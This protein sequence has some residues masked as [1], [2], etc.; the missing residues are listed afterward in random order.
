MRRVTDTPTHVAAPHWRARR[1][2]EAMISRGGSAVDAAIASAAVLCVVYPHMVSLGGD[3]WALISPT[4]N[5]VVA[6]NGTGRAAANAS[7]EELRAVHGDSLPTYGIDTVTVPGG[8]SAW[9]EM[10]QR[11]GVLPW[12]ELFDDALELAGHGVE[13]AS[14]LSREIAMHRDRLRADPGMSSVFFDRDGNPLA[15]GELLRQ[16]A[17]ARTL[18]SIA[19]QGAEEF[20][21]GQLAERFAAAL[22][23][24]G[25]RLTA[26][27][28]ASH[29]ADFVDPLR[30]T[31]GQFEVI[32]SP[33]NSQGFVLLQLLAA[34]EQLGLEGR[35]GVER[36]AEV[37]QL[38]SLSNRERERHLAD[39]AVE[40]VDLDRLLSKNH[41]AELVHAAGNAMPTTAPSTPRP[42]GDTVAVVAMDDEGRS[43]TLIQSIFYAF[44]AM[45][46]ERDT[47]IVLQN[48]G[49][50]LS[51]RP[52]HPARLAGRA[53]PPHTLMPVMLA[54]DS[55]VEYAVGTMGGQ[56]QAQIQSQL[57]HNLVMGDSPQEAVDR[58]RWAVGPYGDPGT[59]AVLVEAALPSDV[60]DLLSAAGLPTIH[61]AT[62]DDRAGH[63]QIVHRTTEGVIA[64]TDPR[65][66]AVEPS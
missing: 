2:G 23:Q 12:K 10:H 47:G 20:Y 52:D 62:R 15:E 6:L 60:R 21:R 57:L 32:T 54:R 59:D 4:P 8:V 37:A 5:E 56:A 51:L 27:D 45:V 35:I 17:L 26:D 42:D 61:G 28:L 66:D 58:P 33:P 41:I 18:E 1:A 55:Q 50:S 38:F 46:L 39:P 48:R 36:S 13:V 40:P 25:S 19:A 22:G 31:Y 63:S 34:F 7:R 44:G 16:P 53:R 9:A 65:A 30:G 3:A 11:W 24:L 43:V 29:T 49:T 64:G 14:A